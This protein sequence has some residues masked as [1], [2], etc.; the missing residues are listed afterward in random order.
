LHRRFPRYHYHPTLLILMHVTCHSLFFVQVL[1]FYL[2]HLYLPNCSRALDV[3]TAILLALQV[4]PYAI[5]T[6]VGCFLFSL[7][8]MNNFISN[9]KKGDSHVLSCFNLYFCSEIKQGKKMNPCGASDSIKLEL[10][11]S[12]FLFS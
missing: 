12:F 11:C 8:S 2:H 6:I 1:V 9:Q 5:P 4:M 10:H 3:A 7:F